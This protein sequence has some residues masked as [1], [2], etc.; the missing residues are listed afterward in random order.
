M[1]VGN[2]FSTALDPAKP[3]LFAEFPLDLLQEEQ[4]HPS[5]ARL[6]PAQPLQL[7]SDPSSDPSSNPFASQNKQYAPAFAKKLPAHRASVQSQS[8]S[9]NQQIAQQQPAQQNRPQQQLAQSQPAQQQPAQTH[10]AQPRLPQQQHTN[11]SAKQQSGLSS[12]QGTRATGQIGFDSASNGPTAATSGHSH[13]HQ[14]KDSQRAAAT[15]EE[16]GE[17]GKGGGWGSDHETDSDD[18]SLEAYDLSEGDD[19]GK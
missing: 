12:R 5:A 1:R 6:N 19:D 17:S 16:V 8:E 18:D 13:Q 9:A 15:E 4:W 10:P 7:K 2:A 11:M 3:L 14:P